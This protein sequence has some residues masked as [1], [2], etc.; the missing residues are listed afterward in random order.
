MCDDRASDHAALQEHPAPPERH[1][2]GS[3]EHAC[4]PYG[5]PGVFAS[6]SCNR[7]HCSSPACVRFWESTFSQRIPQSRPNKIRVS[8][9]ELVTSFP[10]IS[11][12]A[13]LS[14]IEK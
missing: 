12:L 11:S 14:F 2:V 1:T 10:L 13:L 6:L 3:P 5:T 7:R 9:R 4:W 8:F